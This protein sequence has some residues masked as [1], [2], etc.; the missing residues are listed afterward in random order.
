MATTPKITTATN[1]IK[2]TTLPLIDGTGVYALDM[3]GNTIS[4]DY[5]NPGEVKKSQ[6]PA[7]FILSDGPN[8]YA[9][10]TAGEYATGDDT[11]DITTGYTVRIIGYVKVT[12]PGDKQKTGALSDEMDKLISDIILAMH[13][14][15]TL[16]S[17]VDVV[18]L[19]GTDKSLEH[20]ETGIGVVE[21]WFALKWQFLP[22]GASAHV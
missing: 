12:N 17:S 15:R 13:S 16:G 10:L 6:F 4:K 7:L 18:T 2:D 14:D 22:S 5:S 3:T 8:P 9:P 19:I 21:V 1:Y 20:W 11:Q